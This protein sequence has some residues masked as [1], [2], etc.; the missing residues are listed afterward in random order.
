MDDLNKEQVQTND[1]ASESVGKIKDV[2][3]LEEL[4]KVE[5]EEFAEKNPEDISA[6]EPDDK[7]KHTDGVDNPEDSSNDTDDKNKDKK[8][9]EKQKTPISDED[10]KKYDIPEKFKYMEDVVEWGKNAE[11][12]KSSFAAEKDKANKEAETY[13]KELAE[14]KKKLNVQVQKGNITAE[15]KQ[16]AIEAFSEKFSEDP[17]AAVKDTIKELLQEQPKKIDEPN[18]DDPNADNDPEKIKAKQAEFIKERKVEYDELMEG[19][20]KEETESLTAELSQLAKEHPDVSS[21]RD[22]Y[23]IYRG[24][25]DIANEKLRKETEKKNK[26]KMANVSIQS[27]GGKIGSEKTSVEKIKEAKSLADLDE[28]EKDIN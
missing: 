5:N 1:N 25:Q 4:D 26:E 8:P 21:V 7:D 3:T 28:A 9:E 19:K 13:K 27:K 10:R 18:N 17:I 12:A 11:K 2:E 24:K 6:E 22:L 14:L 16:K 15:E 23:F 20:S